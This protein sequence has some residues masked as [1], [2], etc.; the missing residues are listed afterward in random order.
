MTLPRMNAENI[1][2]THFSARYPKMPQSEA[3]RVKPKPAEDV[4]MP[5]DEASAPIADADRRYA[6]A[7]LY[8][9]TLT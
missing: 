6:A 1:L 7:C 8:E 9:H 5:L 4:D 2:L 3:V